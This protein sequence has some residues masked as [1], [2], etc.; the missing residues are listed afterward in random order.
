MK[1]SL[2]DR[3]TFISNITSRLKAM[4]LTTQ[5]FSL[6]SLFSVVFVFA[7]IYI[8][9]QIAYQGLQQF[10]DRDMLNLLSEQISLY[11]LEIKKQLM[12]KTYLNYT[13]FSSKD[14]KL[15]KYIMMQMDEISTSKLNENSITKFK[16]IILHEKVYGCIPNYSNFDVFPYYFLNIIPVFAQANK[17]LGIIVTNYFF[18][19]SLSKEVDAQ[20]NQNYYIK[21]AMFENSQTYKLNTL[22]NTNQQDYIIDPFNYC[23]FPLDNKNDIIKRNSWFYHYFTNFSA[24]TTQSSMFKHLTMKKISDSSRLV[25]DKFLIHFEGFKTG[26]TK[27]MFISNRIDKHRSIITVND[28]DKLLV[29]R[30]IKPQ[31]QGMNMDNLEENVF[32]KEYSIDEGKN[33]LLSVPKNV[34]QIFYYTFFPIK[35]KGYDAR[36]MMITEDMF[37]KINFDD[38]YT[39]NN[40]FKNYIDVFPL[41]GFIQ[42]YLLQNQSSTFYLH[43]EMQDK[44]WDLR[45]SKKDYFN[46]VCLED[47]CK[48]IDCKKAN[49]KASNYGIELKINDDDIFPDCSCLPFYCKIKS[50]VRSSNVLDRLWNMSN[51]E[52][53]ELWNPKYCRLNYKGRAKA[54]DSPNQI[55]SFDVVYNDKL[56]IAYTF[57]LFSETKDYS[58]INCKMNSTIEYLIRY[59]YALNSIAISVLLL[60]LGLRIYRKLKIVSNNITMSD[61]VNTQILENSIAAENFKIHESEVL[62]ESIAECLNLSR[63]GSKVGYDGLITS[64]DLVKNEEAKTLNGEED[65]GIQDELLFI[66]SIIGNNIQ[67]FSLSFSESNIYLEHPMIKN[68][69]QFLKKKEYL[70]PIFGHKMISESKDIVFSE[71]FH[72][73]TVETDGSDSSQNLSEDKNQNDHNSIVKSNLSVQI[74]SELLSTE[75]VC[76][77]KY[78]KNF[79]FRQKGQTP[80]F[81]IDDFI[82]RLHDSNT[83]INELLELDRLRNA[84]DYVRLEIIDPWLKIYEKNLQDDEF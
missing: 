56:D 55:L 12:F 28:Q 38:T 37:L 16:D 19:N 63:Q 34:S 26:K 73:K 59:S 75:F 29:T 62:N 50:E 81:F 74:L 24:N 7:F 49:A 14:L 33:Q 52:K 1:S 60:I 17:Q 22:C 10:I 46:P 69:I 13:D 71:A 6:F 70:R 72:S 65:E 20:C 36:S 57:F 67:D 78:T 8:K 54:I 66:R 27:S 30:H 15:T 53:I 76:V 47:I 4:S 32:R 39:L 11:E 64:N 80:L 43:E 2:S 79:F 58:V 21:T 84:V 82:D 40:N 77:D 61:Q 83:Y 23:E 25:N 31:V 48:M 41:I 3:S 18:G 35:E 5:F 9:F 42:N 51:V 68:Y 44:C 45:S